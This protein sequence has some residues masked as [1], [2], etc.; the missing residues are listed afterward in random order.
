[1]VDEDAAKKT[2]Y[3]LKE[4][5]SRWGISPRVRID[6]KDGRAVNIQFISLALVLEPAGGP[7]LIT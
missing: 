6:E 3:Q 4:G 2:H 7:K 1:M 5:L